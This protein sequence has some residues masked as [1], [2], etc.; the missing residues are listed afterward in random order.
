MLAFFAEHKSVIIIGH[1]IAAGIGLGAA[2]VSDVLFFKFIKDGKVT[3][4]ET[5]ILDTMTAIVWVAIILLIATGAMLFMS[6]PLGYV[7]SPKFMVKMIVVAVIAVNGAIMTNYLHKRMQKISFVTE[8]D[9][10]VKRIAFAAG[11]VSASSWYLSFILGSIRSIPFSMTVGIVGYA[12]L[13]VIAV[14]VSQC[15]YEYYRKKFLKG[16]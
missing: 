4:T 15:M 8:A 10:I 13:L 6:D 12:T 3:S 2:T 1:A 5:P 16:V 9:A 14:A 11:A 7:E